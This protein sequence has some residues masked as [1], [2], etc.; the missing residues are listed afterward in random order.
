MFVRFKCG[1]ILVIHSCQS[2]APHHGSPHLSS[3][4][5]YS[6]LFF[7]CYIRNKAS[8]CYHQRSRSFS[9][10]HPV[11]PS[12][13]QSSSRRISSTQRPLVQQ[14]DS[15]WGGACFCLRIWNA[16]TILP[17]YQSQ[18]YFSPGIQHQSTQGSYD[19]LQLL[20]DSLHT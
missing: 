16:Y 14:L 19:F 9:K 1:G 18:Y 11:E 8:N 13:S 4:H 20:C 3:H 6:Y 12:E 5:G 7:T 10:V 2:K 15:T 17:T